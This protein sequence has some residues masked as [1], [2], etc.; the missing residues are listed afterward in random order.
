MCWTNPPSLGRGRQPSQYLDDIETAANMTN[1]TAAGKD[2]FIRDAGQNALDGAAFHY[3]IYRNLLRFL[4]MDGD[5]SAAYDL[6]VDWV[7]AWNT[8]MM[9]N[10]MLNAETGEFDPRHMYGASN[11]DVFRWPSI[12]YGNE[13]NLLGLVRRHLSRE[14]HTVTNSTA[15]HH[16]HTHA[17]HSPSSVGRGAVFLRP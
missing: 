9:T 17:R 1:A 5:M 8:M 7:S 16:H 13:R 12:T 15:V 14:A 4:G 6:D 11:Q 10:D 2:I 3:S